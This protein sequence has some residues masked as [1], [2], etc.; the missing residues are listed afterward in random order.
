[1]STKTIVGIDVSKLTL[2][3]F[4]HQ[5]NQYI[6]IENNV[7]G[8]KELIKWL[9]QMKIAVSQI[10][11]VFEHTGM[12]GQLLENW[13]AKLNI[14]YS[15]VPALQIKK[16]LGITR[17]KTDKIDALRIAQYAAKNPEK[18]PV[19]IPAEHREQI[20]RLQTLSNYKSKLTVQRAG[21]KA[22]I[23]DTKHFKQLKQT[24]VIVKSHRQM[25]EYLT[26]HI[27]AIEKEIQTLMTSLP[28]LNANYTLLQTITGIGKQTALEVIILTAN[29]SRFENARQFATFSGT[30]PFPHNSGTSVNKRTRVSSLAN[31]K[32]KSLLFMAATS[33]IVHDP[34]LRTY[35]K[36]RME[37]GKS[38]MSIINAVKNKLIGRM[39]AVIQRQSPFV[40][41]NQYAA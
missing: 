14:T 25:I 32:M 3:A 4:C 16:S 13:L 5:T 9:K 37:K 12:Y 24:D 31:R 19:P 7:K 22:A 26:R 35:Y 40:T 39:F 17:G 36:R 38:K 6:V 1:M 15:I 29:F 10:H 21:F 34:E 28:E 11:V 41:L 8:F 30:A 2:D 20:N 27:E 23:E 18:L 33:A